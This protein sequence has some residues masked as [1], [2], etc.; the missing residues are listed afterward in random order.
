M[1]FMHKHIFFPHPFLPILRHQA[2]APTISPGL[3]HYPSFL[4][5]RYVWGIHP[6]IYLFLS[7][8]FNDKT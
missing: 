1:Y 8:I 6:F 3:P 4:F 5:S 2:F 7:F